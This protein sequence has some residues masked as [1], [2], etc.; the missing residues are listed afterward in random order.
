[1][2][3][4]IDARSLSYEYTGIPTYVHDMIM[5]WNMK[6]TD[7]EFFLYTNRPFDLDFDL[8]DNWHIVVDEY[9]Y[10][11]IWIQVRLRSLLKRD[12]I[13]VFWEPM[14]FLP[15]RI[16]GVR[17]VNII[18]DL[19]AYKN[20]R[21]GTVTDNILERLFLMPSCRRADTIV[22][23]SEFTKSD[24][25]K[26]LGVDPDRVRVIYIGDSPYNGRDESYSQKER[27][28]IFSARNIT[29]RDFLLYVGTIEPRKNIITIVK[30]FETLKVKGNFT[31]KLVLAG[32]RGWKSEGIFEVIE[33]SP[34]RE[35]IVVTGFVSATEKECLY[36]EAACLVFPSFEEGFG[37]PIVEAMSVGCPVVTA[38]VSSMPE[39]GGDVAL[40]LEREHLT[41]PTALADRITEVLSLD[42]QERRVL[43][44]KARERALKFNRKESSEQL[45]DVLTGDY[46]SER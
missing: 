29:G 33:S 26:E 13:D 16:P 4:G 38:A 17:Y 32:K 39:V 2:R 41:D 21:Y 6:D 15:V 18:N 46:D 34:F 8:R 1:M 30:A 19:S 22:A 25:V 24:I 23:I 44:D 12:G 14:N 37:L 42:E 5:Y 45:F 40:Y 9:R 7:H 20:H 31:G 35:D 3:I 36:R 43:A 11:G 27:D 10:G 28:N